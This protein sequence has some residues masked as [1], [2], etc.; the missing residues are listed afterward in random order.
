MK[1]TRKTPNNTP[2]TSGNPL[3]PLIVDVAIPLAAYYLLRHFGAGLIPALAISGTLPA[4]RVIWSLIR[5]HT[6]D[7]M[8]LAVLA[9]TVVSIPI[10]FISGS[11]RILLAKESLGTG[12]LGIW[13]IASAL[14]SRPA[15][16]TGLRAFLARTAAK[17]TAWD[18]L[19]AESPKF[20]AGLNAAT[21][22]WGIGFLLEC[23]TRTVLIF[24]LPVTTALWAINIPMAIV[25]V[26]CI[27]VQGN[28]V[29]PMDHMVRERAAE[30]TR[31]ADNAQPT[32]NAHRTDA[33]RLAA[34]GDRPA[35]HTLAR[36]RATAAAA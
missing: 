5:H 12:P 20:R 9:L 27:V 8:A 30:I 36:E 29:T 32:E 15:M 19:T 18:E 22:V 16:A 25:T 31:R 3:L 34:A 2:P 26:G 21:T 4:I 23:A 35:D 28:W 7:G 6:A 24:T 13:L 17:S 11:P 1:A 14:M 33:G 10:A